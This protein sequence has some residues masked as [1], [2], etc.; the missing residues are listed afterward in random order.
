MATK[1]ASKK[2][3]ETAYMLLA[4]IVDATTGTPGFLYV[5]KEA[6]ADLVASGDVE[7]NETMPNP[8]DANEFATRATDQ[9]IAKMPQTESKP[10]AA[11]EAPVKTKSVFSLDTDVPMPAVSG[12]GPTG[13]T[14]PFDE[15]AV[16]Q[17]FFVPNTAERPNVA[18]S[19]A[20]TVYSA[21]QRY[22]QVDPSGATRTNRKGEQVP[23]MIKTR[24][25]VIRSVT[26]NGVQ[27]ARIW[28][29]M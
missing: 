27:G 11:T 20:N 18:K 10:E 13:S 12:R 19:M 28:R 1:K 7:V 16:N 22:A 5:S 29:S 24:K 4:R 15:M 26:E 21:A 14:Y 9:G 23:V 6:S 25:F 8:S 3:E 17:S 2:I